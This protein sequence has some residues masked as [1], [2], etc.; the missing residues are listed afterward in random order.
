MNSV[1]PQ[2]AAAGIG[3]LMVDYIRLI[4]SHQEC[5]PG[6]RDL[7]VCACCLFGVRPTSPSLEK[8]YILDLQIRRYVDLFG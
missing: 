6:L 5:F 3:V 4:I 2:I 1:N 7:S 8:E